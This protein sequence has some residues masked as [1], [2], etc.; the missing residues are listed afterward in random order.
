MYVNSNKNSLNK[1]IIPIWKTDKQ[2]INR[3][4]YLLEKE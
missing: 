4:Q 3:Q 1:I 2:N